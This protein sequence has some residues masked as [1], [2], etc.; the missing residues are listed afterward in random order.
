[1]EDLSHQRCLALNVF[2]AYMEWRR[3]YRGS[4]TLAVTVLALDQ[5]VSYSEPAGG[6]EEDLF[7]S[8]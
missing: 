1:M 6:Q 4:Y 5:R 7:F 8:R 2:K 3:V